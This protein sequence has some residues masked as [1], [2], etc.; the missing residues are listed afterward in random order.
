MY[1]V[2]KV[3]FGWAV[4]NCE[5]ELAHSVWRD[6]RDAEETLRGLKFRASRPRRQYGLRLVA[7]DGIRVV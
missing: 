4:I 7:R 6:M 1:R 5:T 2:Q 3:Y